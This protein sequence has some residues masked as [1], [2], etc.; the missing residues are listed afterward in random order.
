MRKVGNIAIFR[1]ISHIGQQFVIHIVAQS[2][3]GTT[4]RILVDPVTERID[5]SSSVVNFPLDTPSSHTVGKIVPEALSDS[6]WKLP[7]RSELLAKSFPMP[8]I[9][10]EEIRGLPIDPVDDFV[11][12]KTNKDFSR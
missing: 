10:P 12:P 3:S 5:V 1:N 11:E 8:S 4:K 6:R 7:L 9:W 2:Q